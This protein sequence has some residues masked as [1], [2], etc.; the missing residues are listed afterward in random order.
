MTIPSQKVV[1]SISTSSLIKIILVALLLILLY[2]VRELLLVL[3]VS[4]VVASAMDPLVDWLFNKAKFPRGLSVM[5]VYL[6]FLGIVAMTFYFIIPPMVSQFSQL[7]GRL[8]GFQD[9]ISGRATNLANILD[10]LGIS[11]SFSALGQNFARFT[12]NFL[13][14]TAGVFSGLVEFVAILAISFYLVSS[15]D[16]MKNFVKTL[17]PAKHQDR[18]V[19]LTH[20]IQRKIGGWLLGQLILSGF[21]FIFTFVGLTI[22]GVKYALALALLAGLLEIVPYLGPIL[23]AIPAIFVAFVQSPP[24]ALF[25]LILYVVVQQA[26]NHILVPKIM[27]RAIGVSPVI[28][29]VAVLLGFK[30]AGILGMLLAVPVVAGLQVIISDYTASK[31]QKVETA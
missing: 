3:L 4:I 2:T 13:Q 21:I 15:G 28:I 26:E 1:V 11:N 14:T 25:V 24:L 31:E 19:A 27:G 10:Q 17:V 12:S 30:I 8:E 29:L 22:L 5:L 6:I 9:E 7:A 18:A 20:R 16:G 23:S